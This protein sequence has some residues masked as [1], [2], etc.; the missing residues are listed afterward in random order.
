METIS[1]I[2]QRQSIRAYLDKPVSKE[3]INRLF[4]V[5]K[6]SPSSVNSQ[7]CKVAIVSAESLKKL[8]QAIIVASDEKPRHDLNYYPDKWFEPYL[9][10]RRACGLALYD[11]L[12]ISR[13]EVERQREHRRNNFRFFGAPVGV[14]FFV[15]RALAEGSLVDVGIYLQTLMIAATD[16]GLGSCALGSLSEYPDVIRSTLLIEDQYKLVCGMALGYPDMAHPANS[17]RTQ[18]EPLEKMVWLFE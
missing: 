4:E 12:K 17:F 2:K 16:M 13:R 14:L 1:A 3:T 10:R 6:Y 18:R 8:S 5:A 11:A 7:P 9:S 15:D